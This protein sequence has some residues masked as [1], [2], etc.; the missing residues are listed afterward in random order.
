MQ[1]LR[2]SKPSRPLIRQ[3]FL[4][5]RRSVRPKQRPYAAEVNVSRRIRATSIAGSTRKGIAVLIRRG[6][7]TNCPGFMEGTLSTSRG[8]VVIANDELSGFYGRGCAQLSGSY[9]RG[10]A[11]CPG[12]MERGRSY[13]VLRE[14]RIG[15]QGPKAL[16]LAK[17]PRI[18]IRPSRTSSNL[19]SKAQRLYRGYFVKLRRL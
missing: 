13:F 6:C 17:G 10:S 7:S 15:S 5:A 4:P 14:V 1:S 16:V 8:L 12:F 9:G 3:A 2:S 19:R 11:N 18:V